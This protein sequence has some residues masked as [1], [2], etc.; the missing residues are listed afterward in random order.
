MLVVDD[1]PGL[2]VDIDEEAAKRYPYRRSYLPIP[3]RSDGS[4][5]GY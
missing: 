1:A 2:G 5:I 3:R 4:V